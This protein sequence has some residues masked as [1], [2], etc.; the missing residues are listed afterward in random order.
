MDKKEKD[1]LKAGLYGLVNG[2]IGML[3]EDEITHYSQMT[4]RVMA[5]GWVQYLSLALTGKELPLNKQLLP[6]DT[7]TIDCELQKAYDTNLAQLPIRR[8]DVPGIMERLA[9]TLFEGSSRVDLVLGVSIEKVQD[10]YIA[11][12]C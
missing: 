10:G 12:R 6:N 1:E 4:G 2:E 5:S 7:T 11:K 8:E 3:D 9:Q